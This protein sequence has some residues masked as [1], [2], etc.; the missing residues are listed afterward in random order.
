MGKSERVCSRL[1]KGQGRD[2]QKLLI[3]GDLAY[4]L[5]CLP[6]F[7][8]TGQVHL[9]ATDAW[10]VM[11]DQNIIPAIQGLYSEGKEESLCEARECH[12]DTQ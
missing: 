7:L 8:I 12:N 3:T 11:I 10:S 4:S 6:F 5:F 9:G 1:G 2:L